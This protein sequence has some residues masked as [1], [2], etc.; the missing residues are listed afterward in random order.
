[1]LNYYKKPLSID[2]LAGKIPPQAPE[3]EEAVLSALMLDPDSLKLIK[4]ILKPESFYKDAHQKIYR[5][6]LSLNTIDLF[7]VQEALKIS[8]DLESVG[9]PFALSILSGKVASASNIETHAQI[10]HQK[11]IAREWIRITSEI[12]NKAFDDSIDIED[13]SEYSNDEVSKL[14]KSSNAKDSIRQALKEAEV[15]PDEEIKEGEIIIWVKDGEKLISFISKGNISTFIGK[16]K[17]RKTFLL[18]MIAACI[19][20]GNLYNKFICKGNYKVAYFDTEQ[21][22]KRTQKVIKRIIKLHPKN[23]DLIKIF[24]LRKYGKDERIRMIDTYL[25][26]FRPD[27][28]F[29]DG[30]RDLVADINDTK[31]ADAK[32]DMMMRWSEIYDCHI[33]VVLHQNKG[34]NNARGHIGSELMN[35]S[36]TV[37]SASRTKGSEYTDVSGDFVRDLPFEDFQFFVNDEGLP[38][39]DMVK[40]DFVREDEGKESPF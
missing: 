10:I 17:S 38:E 6:I 24:S 20:A 9:G 1:M 39:I 5:A 29:I 21:G 33:A 31:E 36:E 23:K 7:T 12:Q 2:N 30:V 22:R 32:S 15:N 11:F 14:I 13:L 37:V 26:E 35:R 34:D 18:T 16:A 19:G 27:L 25:E 28:V 3:L 40:G 4:D 8:G